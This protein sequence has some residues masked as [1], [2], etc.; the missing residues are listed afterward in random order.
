[1]SA[2]SE[3]TELT[4]QI[5]GLLTNLDLACDK[6]TSAGVPPDGNARLSFW[7]DVAGRIGGPAVADRGTSV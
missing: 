2:A 5:Q 7:R 6:P 3:L 1:V 4:T